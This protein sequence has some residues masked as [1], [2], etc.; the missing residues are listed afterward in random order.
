MATAF[1]K[2][3]GQISTVSDTAAAAAPA[4]GTPAAE[5]KKK[6]VQDLFKER[7]AASGSAIGNYYDS[8]LSAQKQSLLDAYNA[9]TAAQR[10]A[11]DTVRRVGGTLKNDLA[12]QNARN[13]ANINQFADVRGVNRQQGSQAALSLGNA[14][15]AAMA[16]MA[17]RQQ[18]A[19]EENQ[20]QQDL[21]KVQYQ[22]RVQAAIADKDYKQAAALLDNYNNENKWRDQQAALLASYGN[23]DPYKNLYGDETGAAMQRVWAAQNP[24]VA[25]RTGAIDAE[26]YRNITGQYPLGYEPPS[27]GGGW[28]GGW[29]IPG[30]KLKT[31]SADGPGLFGENTGGGPVLTPTAINAAERYVVGG[32]GSKGPSATQSASKGGSRK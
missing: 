1:N 25:Y 9:S 17:F 27:S 13:T 20:R 6:T 21:A 18:Q 10:S 5:T 19:L 24:E 30:G 12:V 29:Y 23:F 31:Y 7:E 16:N 22:A 26:T 2:A 15:N 8:G 28:G 3:T 11:A 4:S 32:G 14:G